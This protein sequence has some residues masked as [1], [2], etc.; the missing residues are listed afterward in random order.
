MLRHR[1]QKPIRR[2]AFLAA[3]LNLSWIAPLLIALGQAVRFLKFAV[4]AGEA[5]TFDLGRPGAFPAYLPDGRVWVMKDVGGLYALDA[6]CTHLGCIVT[7]GHIP[8]VA[9]ECPCHG[10]RFGQD[11]A[12]LRGPATVPL[13]H[14]RLARDVDGQLLV[15]RSQAV[16][17]GFRLAPE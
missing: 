17:A 7:A 14:L 11:G 12:L 15:D 10:S 9:F 6:V 5:T 2:R 8:D 4:P 13:R 3:A 16:D 1:S